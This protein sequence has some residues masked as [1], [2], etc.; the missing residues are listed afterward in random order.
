ML[1]AKTERNRQRR[2]RQ[3][4]QR[5]LDK[6]G[7]SILEEETHKLIE[8]LSSKELKIVNMEVEDKDSDKSKKDNSIR[9][10][11]HTDYG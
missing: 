1:C 11:S 8:Q 10:C 2:H 7:I 9:Y 4:D 6:Q 3:N 5:K